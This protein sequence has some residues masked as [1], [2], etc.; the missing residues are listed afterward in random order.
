M[1]CVDVFCGLSVLLADLFFVCGFGV[2][3]FLLFSSCQEIR[4]IKKI[5]A[6]LR[7]WYCFELKG[8]LSIKIGKSVCF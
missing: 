8:S 7:L 4:K 6:W 1:L 2:F 3:F 5:T